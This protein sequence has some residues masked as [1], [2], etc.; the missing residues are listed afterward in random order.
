MIGRIVLLFID[1]EAKGHV[2]I[3]GRSRDENLLRTAVD[4]ILRTFAA[5]EETGGFEDHVD[6]QVAPWQFAWIALGSAFGPTLFMRLANQ[7][8]RPSGV[9]LSILTGFG[10]AVILY[11]APNTPGDIAE[12]LLP[13]CCA[14]AVLFGFRERD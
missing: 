4:V 8:L 7:K 10:L 14:L 9:L 3:L 5:T 11:L 13:F 1:A 6:T 2:R 12:R